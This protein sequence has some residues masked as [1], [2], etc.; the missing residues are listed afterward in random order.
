MLSHRATNGA[1]FSA[2]ARNLE[3]ASEAGGSGAVV[4]FYSRGGWPNNWPRQATFAH[5]APQAAASAESARSIRFDRMTPSVM[6][7]RPATRKTT[8]STTETL[9]SSLEREPPRIGGL[10]FD[11]SGGRRQAQLAGGRLLHGRARRR[12]HSG[13]MLPLSSTKTAPSNLAPRVCSSSQ[14]A[15]KA[16]SAVSLPPSGVTDAD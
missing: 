10:T 9:R 5:A 13:R 15:A 11:T 16:T 4:I 6:P 12:V 8:A 7:T 2:M 1:A 14:V 3:T